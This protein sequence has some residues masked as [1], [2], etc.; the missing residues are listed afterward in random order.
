MKDDAK[1]DNDARSTGRSEPV[2]NLLL[3]VAER[4]FAERGIEAVSLNQIA[5]AAN[6]RNSTVIQYHFG[7]K[8][9]LLQAITQRRTQV[10]NRR[11]HE[12]LA[13]IDGKDRQ[14]DLT[15]A[16]KAM[17]VPYGEH[18]SEEGG[19]YFVR[20]AAQLYSDPRFEMFELIK[21]GHTSGMREAGRLLRDI[22]SDLP[23]DVVKHRL[24]LITTLIFSA[25]AEREKLR[26]AGRHVGVARLHTT[27]FVDD[28]VAMAVGALNA[29]YGAQELTHEKK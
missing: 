26:A 25:F 22:L 9:G 24:A 8:T 27:H 12:L 18:L 17:S 19:T 10:V 28:L 6:Q 3:D 21:G 23:R 20:F 2:R 16:V 1:L 4:L 7:S 13:Q 29:P 15:A 14:A 5:K 11:R